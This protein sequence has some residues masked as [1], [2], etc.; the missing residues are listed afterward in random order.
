MFDRYINLSV[1]F[2]EN[3]WKM[4]RTKN[5]EKNSKKIDKIWTKKILN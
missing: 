3:L 2:C 5:L 4:A 1:L